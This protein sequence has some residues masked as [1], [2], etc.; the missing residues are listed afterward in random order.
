MET[1]HGVRF[2]YSHRVPTNEFREAV[3][4]LELLIQRQVQPRG[5]LVSELDCLQYLVNGIPLQSFELT[6]RTYDGNSL[7][8]LY[9]ATFLTDEASCNFA[10]PACRKRKEGRDS[11]NE[12][13]AF[14]SSSMADVALWLG[15]YMSI[16]SKTSFVQGP[17]RSGNAGKSQQTNHHTDK[18]DDQQIPARLAFPQKQQQTRH[19][20]RGKSPNKNTH[21]KICHRTQSSDH[22]ITLKNMHTMN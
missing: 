13:Y 18:P 14:F 4:C 10:R 20:K 15:S 3:G 1:H 5:I 19:T 21:K 12:F 17:K 11:A 8:Q 9:G 6:M 22:C 16:S 7:R 2:N